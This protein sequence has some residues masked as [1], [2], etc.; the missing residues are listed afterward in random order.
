MRSEN[1]DILQT[2]A[3][4]QAS[5]HS[6]ID[7]GPGS[8]TE[9]RTDVLDYDSFDHVA[10]GFIKNCECP[11]VNWRQC[12]N[13]LWKVI[14]ADQKRTRPDLSSLSPTCRWYYHALDTAFAML[15]SWSCGSTTPQSRVVGFWHSWEAFNALDSS[16]GCSLSH[17]GTPKSVLTVLLFPHSITYWPLWVCCAVGRVTRNVGVEK[18]LGVSIQ[19]MCSDRNR[20][21]YMCTFLVWPH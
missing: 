18:C 19:A 13:L 3:N 4:L 5:S 9:S 11:F 15:T 17:F 10:A 7:S 8:Y 21:E 6:Y 14:G 2:P 16:C 1:N 20:S 12:S